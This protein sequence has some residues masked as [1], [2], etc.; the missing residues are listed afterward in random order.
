MLYPISFWLLRSC[1]EM[2]YGMQVHD[3]GGKKGIY[4]VTI[5]ISSRYYK[6]LCRHI[7]NLPQALDH[8][9]CLQNLNRIRPPPSLL[10]PPRDSLS[11]KRSSRANINSLAFRG[12][13]NTRITDVK[14]SPLIMRSSFSTPQEAIP[15]NPFNDKF[16]TFSRVKISRKESV[17]IGFSIDKRR[18]AQNKLMRLGVNHFRDACR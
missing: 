13:D 16:L 18:L 12:Q 8:A 10:Y 15:E 4:S 1:G 6:A 9:A 3:H 11:T 5:L 7:L 2:G 17:G 14:D